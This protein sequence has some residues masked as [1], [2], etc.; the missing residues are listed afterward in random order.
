MTEII[1]AIMPKTIG[2][3]D[4]A[5]ALV[6]GAVSHVQIDVM[7]GKMVPP[8]SW[9][10]PDFDTETAPFIH[11]DRGLP[12][13][14]D[15]NYEFDLMIRNPEKFVEKFITLGGARI[16]IHYESGPKEAIWGAVKKAQSMNTEVGLAIDTT[17]PNNVLE[18]F[19]TDEQPIDFVQFMGIARIGYQSEP[20]DERVIPN[21]KA[22]RSEYPDIIIS[23]DGA[24]N[25]DSAPRLVRVGANRLVSGSAIFGSENPRETIRT[26]QAL[27]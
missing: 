22:L 18:E 26:L 8:T 2:E 4:S 7:D 21:I 13:W 23:V 17:T 25:F 10:F 19:L 14:E 6:R 27:G 16:I 20:F 15:V 1:P 3:L 24:V 5:V 11:E 12:F 9:P